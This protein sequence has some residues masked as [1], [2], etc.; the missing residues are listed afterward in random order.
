MSDVKNRIRKYRAWDGSNMLYSERGDFYL[1]ANGKVSV[2]SST[3]HEF[4]EREYPIMDFTGL[5]DKKG[6]EIYEG[7]CGV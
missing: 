3:G 5:H 4:Y 1:T 7:G 2:P 6:K